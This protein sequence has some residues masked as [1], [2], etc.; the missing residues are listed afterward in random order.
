MPSAIVQL[1]LLVREYDEAIHFYIEKLGF[2]LLEDTDL[3][4]GKR[5]VRIAPPGGAGAQLLLSRATTPEQQARV[6]N[7]TGGKV[8]LFIETD[9]FARDYAALQGHGVRFTGPPRREAYGTV[10]V[11]EDLYGNKYDLIQ[12][13]G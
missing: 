5:W 9:D 2:D 13:P 12:R 8:F 3:G 4:S 7:Q 6:G 1:A 10:V 11:F